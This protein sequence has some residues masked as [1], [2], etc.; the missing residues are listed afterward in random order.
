MPRALNGAIGAV[1][2]GARCAEATE[3]RAG[4]RAKRTA[5][6]WNCETKLARTRGSI[7]VSNRASLSQD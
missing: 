2:S 3:Y 7:Q 6:N 4:F 5:Q 1:F